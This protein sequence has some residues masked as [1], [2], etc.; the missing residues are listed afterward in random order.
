MLPESGGNYLQALDRVNCSIARS[1]TSMHLG[2]YLFWSTP[3]QFLSACLNAI[4]NRRPEGGYAAI[5]AAPDLIGEEREQVD[6]MLMEG[7]AAVYRAPW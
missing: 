6:P 5:D 4:V 1:P 7:S 3:F 2:R